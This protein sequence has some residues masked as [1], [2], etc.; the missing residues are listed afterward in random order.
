MNDETIR[1]IVEEIAPQLSGRVMGKV[2]QLSRTS[3]A[4]DF[5]LSD[6][7]YLFL[8]VDPGIAPR[9][10]LI[11]RRVRD[12]EKQSLQP[13]SFVLALRK[14]LSG[15]ELAA[16][17]KDDSDRIVRFSFTGRDVVGN[18]Q[19]RTLVAQLTGRA[20]NL[21]LL[22]EHGYIIDTLRTL[23]GEGQQA[24]EPYAP[25][26][27]Q[28]TARTS[29]AVM[30]RGPF[31]TLSEAADN[32]YLELEAKRA[33]EAQAARER[34]RLNKEITQRRKLKRHLEED[35]KA[36]GDADEH[37]RAGD[38]LLAN[39]ATAERRAGKVVIKDYY[40][41]GSP[42][43]ELEVDENSSLQEE[44]ARRFARYTKARRAGRE[45]AERLSVIEKELKRLEAER[46]ELEGFILSRDS[47][48][49]DAL[50][51]GAEGKA[52]DSQPQRKKQQPEQ[53]PGTRRYTSSDG[54]EILV[55]RTARD[56][57]NLTFR[58]ARPYDLWLHAGDYPGSHV[59][60]R[61]PT[62]AEIPHRTLVE[63]AQ[64]AA[65]FSQA[66][67]DAKVTI[68]YTQR[69]FLSKPKGAAPGLVRISSFRSITVEPKTL[70]PA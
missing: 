37:K 17:T 40:A 5:R 27:A 64:L 50:N 20:A 62:R 24:G 70:N 9:L 6:G 19:E 28:S 39:L 32:Y 34:S 61:N 16:L 58:V 3:L 26:P 59:V 12:L 8:S 54:Y 65:H 55:G 23:Q 10:Y 68:H 46:E 48:A 21:L 67:N 56:N 29:K 4:V 35:L 57:D 11:E 7:R 51:A 43:I 41:E 15:A 38:L 25:P 47:S 18:T 2:F 42:E 22:N 33:F 63:A 66:R 13:F 45:I 30:E 1:A 69:K 60:V 44:A 52:P 53:V 31:V 49:L 14:H 36:H